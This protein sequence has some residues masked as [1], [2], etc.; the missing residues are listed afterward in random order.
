MAQ[1][2]IAAPEIELEEATNL[3]QVQRS[4]CDVVIIHQTFLSEWIE[5]IQ[6][7]FLVLTELPTREEL[8]LF[9]ENR[10][11]FGYASLCPT[12]E[13]LLSYIQTTNFRQRNTFWLDPSLTLLLIRQDK[14]DDFESEI[15]TKLTARSRA[16]FDLLKQRKTTNE[17]AEA[18]DIA[19]CTV[20]THKQ[21]ICQKLGVETDELKSVLAVA[22][23]R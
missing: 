13:P 20:R 9:Q 18:L 21:H 2:A 12:L 6:K 19:V 11:C 14:I 8:L 10:H 1:I 16:V 23:S 22:R 3:S 15:W 17:I 4:N 5:A 7:P